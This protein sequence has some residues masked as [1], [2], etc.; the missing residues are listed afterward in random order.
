MSEA[1][2]WRVHRARVG[3]LSRD[4]ETDD[5]DLRAARRELA[6]SVLEERVRRVLAGDDCPSPEQRAKIAAL[7]LT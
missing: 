6:G 2:S 1:V 3:A 5:P 7:L 4:R